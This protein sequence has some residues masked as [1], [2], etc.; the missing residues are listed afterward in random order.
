MVPHGP[1][2]LRGATSPPAKSQAILQTCPCPCTPLFS[3][4]KMKKEQPA[5]KNEREKGSLKPSLCP[6]S[7]SVD[8]RDEAHDLFFFFSDVCAEDELAT[9]FVRH[10]LE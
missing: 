2:I 10:L 9:P 6:A 3:N 7:T 1:Q 5:L 4:L 8:W